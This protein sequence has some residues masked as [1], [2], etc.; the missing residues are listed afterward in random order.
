MEE[1]VEMVEMVEM[2]ELRRDLEDVRCLD[3]DESKLN[4]DDD[5]L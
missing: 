1:M 4:D 3:G 2:E 5:T